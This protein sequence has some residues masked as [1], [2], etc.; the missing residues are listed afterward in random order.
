MLITW[1]DHLSNIATKF[2][3]YN[4]IDNID[5]LLKSKKN[6]LFEEI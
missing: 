4:L 1:T 2:E 3:N 5:L 6:T